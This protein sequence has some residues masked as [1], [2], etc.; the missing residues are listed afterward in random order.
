MKTGCKQGRRGQEWKGGKDLWLWARN[1]N[2]VSRSRDRLWQ[3]V[4]NLLRVRAIDQFEHKLEAVLVLLFACRHKLISAS[5]GSESQD[6][7][8]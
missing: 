6:V 7:L 5:Y 2:R 8:G 4:E 1:R 3:Q